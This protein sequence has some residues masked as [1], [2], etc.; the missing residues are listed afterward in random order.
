MVEI[1]RKELSEYEKSL[2]ANLRKRIYEKR[3]QALKTVL[4]KIQFT[5][6]IYLTVPF[7]IFPFIP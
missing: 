4:K 3:R 5:G 1:A 6:G 7:S 2:L